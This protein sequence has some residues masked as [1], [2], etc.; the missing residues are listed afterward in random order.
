MLGRTGVAV[1]TSPG[2]IASSLALS[3]ALRNGRLAQ[4][5]GACLQKRETSNTSAQS[6]GEA[7]HGLHGTE[8]EHAK[9]DKYETWY[10]YPPH[11]E[12]TRHSRMKI[13]FYIGQNPTAVYREPDKNDFWFMRWQAVAM[14]TFMWSW[15]FWWWF[16]EPGH[17]TGEWFVPDRYLWTDTELGIPPLEAGPAPKVVPDHATLL[18]LSTKY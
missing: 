3:S 15:I 1:L 9:K 18:S 11:V 4:L 16:W 8:A 13:P 10:E 6:P 7:T 17:V 5:T 2:R 12:V 14:A